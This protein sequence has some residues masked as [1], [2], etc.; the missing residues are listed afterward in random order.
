MPKE[1]SPMACTTGK[2]ANITDSV[3]NAD[4]SAQTDRTIGLL[5]NIRKNIIRAQTKII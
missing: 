4:N 1:L 2:N 5:K 3:R